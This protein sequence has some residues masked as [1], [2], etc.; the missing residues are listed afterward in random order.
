MVS[1]PW[2]KSEQTD[3]NL[4]G[5]ARALLRAEL[6]L[7]ELLHRDLLQELDSISAT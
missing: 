2:V 6:G 5:G 7:L 4:D 3:A 1:H